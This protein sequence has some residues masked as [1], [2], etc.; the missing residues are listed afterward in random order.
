MA[1]ATQQHAKFVPPTGEEFAGPREFDSPKHPYDLFMESEG[2]PIYREIG[3]RDVRDLELGDWARTGGRGAYIQLI[4]TEELWGMF[5]LEI[6]P[7]GVL[8]VEQHIYE[9][10]M[11][12]VEGAG[13]TEVWPT[14]GESG[15]PQRFEWHDGSLFGIPLNAPHRLVNGS[16]KRALLIAGTTAPPVINL[17]NNSEFVFAN[18]YAFR[19]RYDAERSFFDYHDELVQDP[20]RGRA[21]QVTSLIPDLVNLELPLDNQRGPGMRRIQPYMAN[22]RFYMKLLEYKVGRY[23]P[24]HFHPPSAVLVCVKGGGYTYTWP[25]ELGLTPWKDG[26]EELVKRVDYG[27]GGM[28]A[29]APGSGDWVHQHFA[30][31]AEPL[32]VL[33]MNGPPSQRI[34]GLFAP[35]GQKLTSSN[36]GISEGGRSIEYWREDPHIREEFEAELARV[37][38]VSTMPPELYTAP[39]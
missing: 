13:T 35:P 5:L 34:G 2:I 14:G 3:F 1:E 28:V 27:P 26:K 29:A 11:Y 37:G 8:E 16:N 33:A 38:R 9:K 12:V 39:Q 18:S 4:G 25:R 36:L 31:S 20:V 23:S 22:A 32:R 21:M 30:A 17:F 19:E 10:I 7:D 15:P 24:A 6:P